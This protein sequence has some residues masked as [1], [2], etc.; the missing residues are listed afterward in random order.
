MTDDFSYPAKGELIAE[1]V[2]TDR[3]ED[4]PDFHIARAVPKCAFQCLPGFRPQSYLL[5]K[6]VT[7]T[8]PDRESD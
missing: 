1:Y 6:E 2:I 8:A 5:V 4:F 7:D 3:P